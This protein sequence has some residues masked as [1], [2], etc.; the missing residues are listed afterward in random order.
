MISGEEQF[1]VGLE[2]SV[3][4]TSDLGGLF[5]EGNNKII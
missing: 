5:H 1:L 4:L 3:A 2:R